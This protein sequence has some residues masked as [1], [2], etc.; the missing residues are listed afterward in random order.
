MTWCDV[1]CRVCNDLV[2]CI[3]KGVQLFGV[4]STAGCAIT[5]CALYC[6]VCNESVCFIL[7]CVH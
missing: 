5:W 3:L 2:C 6:S 4:L 1:Y 7:L